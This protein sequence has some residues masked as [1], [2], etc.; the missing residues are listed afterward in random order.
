MS[1][2]NVNFIINIQTALIDNDIKSNIKTLKESYIQLNKDLSSLKEISELSDQ[3]LA[4]A[5]KYELADVLV[6]K[7]QGD[8]CQRCRMIKTDVGSDSNYP[9]FCARC[10]KIVAEEYPETKTE[11]FDDQEW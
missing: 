4:N 3:E 1:E 9:T 5:D 10:A 7:A 6:E 8:V 2:G 11:G